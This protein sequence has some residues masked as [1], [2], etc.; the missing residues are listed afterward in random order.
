[1]REGVVTRMAILS[2]LGSWRGLDGFS[3]P[4][5]GWEGLE[6]SIPSLTGR[7]REG[8]FFITV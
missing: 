4:W 5:G 1:V 3:S 6:V 2:P 7:V 8:L